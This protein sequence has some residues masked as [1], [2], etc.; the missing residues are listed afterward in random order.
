[1]PRNIDIALTLQQA[2]SHVKNPEPEYNALNE[3][4]R[5]APFSANLEQKRIL[6]YQE[7]VSLGS[8]ERL[9]KFYSKLML[10]TRTSSAREAVES[11]LEGR[12]ETA[13][14]STNYAQTLL[15]ST[16][17]ESE[18]KEEVSVPTNNRIYTKREKRTVPVSFLLRNRI[19]FRSPQTRRARTGGLQ[20]NSIMPGD[21]AQSVSLEYSFEHSS[22]KQYDLSRFG[23]SLSERKQLEAFPA[24]A[25]YPYIFDNL[26]ALQN[27]A[28]YGPCVASDYKDLTVQS[29]VSVI[30]S[31]IPFEFTMVKKDAYNQTILSDS[32]SVLSAT[33]S[34]LGYAEDTFTSILGSSFFSIQQGGATFNIAVKPTFSSVQY[35]KQF[36]V[37]NSS[38]TFYLQGTDIQ[39]GGTMRS[40]LVPL[41]LQQGTNVCPPGY[42]LVMDTDGATRGSG[43]CSL[44]QPG[45]YSINAMAQS[46]GSISSLPACIDCPAGCNCIEG[47]SHVQCEPG[48]WLAHGG[49][50]VLVSCPRGYQLVNSTN[51]DSSGVFSNQNQQCVACLPGKY[52][53]DPNT[54][55]CTQCP[56]GTFLRIK[57]VC[58]ALLIGILQERPVM[59]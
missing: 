41:S 39:T 15:S 7:S 43:V 18:G 58:I 16:S 26:C 56:K 48:Q 53:V 55:V 5:G 28:L 50:Y 14:F 34:A 47:G 46:P 36:V 40:K 12:Y 45:K 6:D 2:N 22:S 21:T 1:M 37:L 44:C 20:V 32:A 38:I 23:L 59:G 29:T 9:D 30:Y 35:E 3:K 33:A 25:A 10:L 42:I 24:S 8:F 51:G 57:I 31:G 52:I 54:D 27:F 19:I 4:N 17:S 49:I 11:V 13:F